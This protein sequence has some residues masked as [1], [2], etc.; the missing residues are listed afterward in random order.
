MRGCVWKWMVLESISF[1]LKLKR[2]EGNWGSIIFDTYPSH[3]HPF[4]AS[5]KLP[6]ILQPDHLS[7]RMPKNAFL[8]LRPCSWRRFLPFPRLVSPKKG[9]AAKV[10]R[11]R[12]SSMTVI[13]S[14]AT[15]GAPWNRPLLYKQGLKLP[16][17]HWN[18]ESCR[19]KVQFVHLLLLQVPSFYR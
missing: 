3:I 8:L 11:S 7:P 2:F 4:D 6:P 12:S 1:L 15:I 13:V 19:T 16:I 5:P 18:H 14:R 10:R 17:A 9:R